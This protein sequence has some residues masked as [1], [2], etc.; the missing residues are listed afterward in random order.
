MRGERSQASGVAPPRPGH[1]PEPPTTFQKQEGLQGLQS[2]KSTN[3]RNIRKLSPP[4]QGGRAKGI[5]QV[6]LIPPRWGEAGSWV[7][8]PRGGPSLRPLQWPPP[9]TRGSSARDSGAP[10]PRG[11]RRPWRP[12]LPPGNGNWR[13]SASQADA[14]VLSPPHSLP[15]SLGLPGTLSD[16]GQAA[17]APQP[18]PGAP[19]RT[20]T[21]GA[22]TPRT[23]APEPGRG[24]G[25]R[26][27]GGLEKGAPSRAEGRPPGRGE[28]R[29]SR[30]PREGRL[31]QPALQGG[32]VCPVRR[33]RERWGRRPGLLTPGG[34][35]AGWN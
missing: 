25:R 27:S 33:M 23:L 26:G 31:R 17:H 14:P 19:P 13:G 11:A 34:M 1:R 35:E 29:S 18:A 20:L 6:S 3:K 16:T 9:R 30:D 21:P 22:G 28:G 32:W 24:R 7:P 2:F 8:A 10:P 5:S 4:F 15:E 12:R